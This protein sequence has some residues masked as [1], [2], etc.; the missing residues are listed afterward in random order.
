MGSYK[1]DKSGLKYPGFI[2][3]LQYIN[4]D[5]KYKKNSSANER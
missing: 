2:E 1:S 4:Q 3:V 5:V